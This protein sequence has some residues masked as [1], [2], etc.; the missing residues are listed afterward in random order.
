MTF[1]DWN[2][3]V[4]YGDSSGR[5]AI[6]AWAGQQPVINVTWDDAKQYVAWLSKMT[7]KPYRL[8]SESEW[9][10][11]ARAGTTTAYFWGDQIGTD[12]ADCKAAAANGT[13]RNRPRWAHSIP[14]SLA[15][16]TWPET[17]GSGPRLLTRQL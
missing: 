1:D 5:S 14:T 9:E 16:M 10:Y 12:N 15:S 7:G 3:C 11:A 2:A 17:S 13:G 6:S 4:A 8:L